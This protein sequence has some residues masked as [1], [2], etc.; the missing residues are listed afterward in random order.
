MPTNTG[1]AV[2]LIQDYTVG[3]RMRTFDNLPAPVRRALANATRDWSVRQCHIM[4]HGGD[5]QRGIKAHTVA[6]LVALLA[7]NDRLAMER[8]RA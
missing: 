1:S 5:A 7:R 4:L 8:S 2:R 3:Q 6:S